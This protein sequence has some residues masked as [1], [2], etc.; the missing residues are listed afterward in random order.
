MQPRTHTLVA[1]GT[2][3]LVASVLPTV[4]LPQL[5]AHSPS[6]PDPA[7][8]SP[9]TP[10]AVPPPGSLPSRQGAAGPEGGTGELDPP[11]PDGVPGP[12]AANGVP[13]PPAR[14]GVPGPPPSPGAPGP[15]A[16][17]GVPG[18]PAANGPGRGLPRGEG[19]VTAAELLS[20]VS[21]CNQISDGLYRL[22]ESSP[23]TVPVCDANGAVFWKA[24]MDI[25]CDGQVTTQCGP[26]TDRSFQFQTAYMQA[27]GRPLKS[28]E[29]PYVVV[30]NP[31]PIWDHTSSGIRGGT[32]AAVIH[33]DNVQYGVVGDTGPAEIIGEASYATARALGIPG[34]PNRGGTSSGVTYILFKDSGIS[35]IEDQSAAVQLGSELA[36]K[37]VDEN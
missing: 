10:G 20:R 35:P 28:E 29:L 37:F 13:G 19:V 5:A 15:S 27:D 21:Q 16:P 2:A 8:A 11:T 7:K 32:L 30:P 23:A 1:V 26:S 9:M 22:D 17:D 4:V 31:S 36:R 24:D 6:P 14:D 12:P 34:D 18:P 3:L 25:D 33:G